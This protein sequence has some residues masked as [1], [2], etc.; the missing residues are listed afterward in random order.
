MDKH[1]TISATGKIEIKD[2]KYEI[3]LSV[4]NESGSNLNF[5]KNLSTRRF[6]PKLFDAETYKEFS[7]KE[8]GTR[9]T[10][11]STNC[12]ANEVLEKDQSRS[13]ILDL[14]TLFEIELNKKY[15]LIVFFTGVDHINS[16]NFCS[17][18]LKFEFETRTGVL[19]ENAFYVSIP[20]EIAKKLPI[21]CSYKDAQDK[22]NHSRMI[23]F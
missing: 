10:T 17:N 18:V 20:K 7:R 4:K 23:I 12:F 6:N 14:A 22:E 19:S 8:Q 5:P 2:Q 16:I 11:I 1:I 13:Y 21:Y 15:I 3:E 9:K